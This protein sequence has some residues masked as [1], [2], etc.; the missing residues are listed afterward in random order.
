M[1]DIVTMYIRPFT[2][3]TN[4]ACPKVYPRHTCSYSPHI[5]YKVLKPKF[6]LICS[7]SNQKMNHARQKKEIN[8]HFPVHVTKCRRNT[9]MKSNEPGIFKLLTVLPR[10]K[11][12]KIKKSCTKSQVDKSKNSITRSN[13]NNEQKRKERATT[14]QETR[15]TTE[16]KKPQTNH[17][18]NA[19][20]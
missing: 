9:C 8:T 4:L 11:I 3:K 13:L 15:K 6:L 18:I 2:V 17:G 14:S 10:T 16:T 7:T 20:K 12:S 19:R 1:T 5:F